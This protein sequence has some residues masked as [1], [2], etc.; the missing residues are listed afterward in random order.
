MTKLFFGKIIPLKY[1]VEQPARSD[2][3]IGNVYGG[4]DGWVAVVASVGT[5][6]TMEKANKLLTTCIPG[7]SQCN[8]SSF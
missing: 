8:N 2:R 3:D 6:Y 5:V 7:D 4:N 1:I